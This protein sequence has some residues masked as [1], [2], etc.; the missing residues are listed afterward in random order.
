MVS[1]ENCRLNQDMG[2]RVLFY[3]KSSDGGGTYM[4]ACHGKSNFAMIGT[5][6]SI[7]DPLTDDSRTDTPYRIH[8]QCPM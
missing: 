1:V 3:T 4:L 5:P 2:V 7:C 8:I 6:L